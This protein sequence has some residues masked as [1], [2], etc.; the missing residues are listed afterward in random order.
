MEPLHSHGLPFL[1]REGREQRPSTLH[2]PGER[3]NS[4]T[5]GRLREELTL[6]RPN[7]GSFPTGAES[8]QPGEPQGSSSSSLGLPHAAGMGTAQHTVRGGHPELLKPQRCRTQRAE[9]A[10]GK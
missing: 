9:P 4:S 8:P 6:H 5:E 10:Q 2:P 1:A 3:S 7:Q